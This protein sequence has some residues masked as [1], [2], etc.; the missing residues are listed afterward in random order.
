MAAA[1]AYLIP[2]FLLV[3]FTLVASRLY[4]V[5]ERRSLESYPSGRPRPANHPM[6]YYVWQVKDR[7]RELAR[8]AA[9]VREWKKAMAMEYGVHHLQIQL[10]QWSP[11]VEKNASATRTDDGHATA[12]GKPWALGKQH[13]ENSGA[14]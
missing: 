1:L 4:L 2:L 11:P 8:T 10:R 14:S 12:V 7:S 3:T 13:A 9:P 6:D 5:L